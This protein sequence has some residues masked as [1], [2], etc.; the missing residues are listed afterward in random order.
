MKRFPA[1]LLLASFPLLSAGQWEDCRSGPFEIWTNGSDRD[2]RQ[3]L[4]RLEQ[5]DR[6]RGIFVLRAGF[7]AHRLRHHAGL[8]REMRGIR[9]VE[10]V[11]V[12][13][14]VSQHER[15]ILLAV[16]IDHAVE[17]LF[18]EL[19]R[20]VAAV[21]ELDLGAED[22]RLDAVERCALFLPRELAFAALAER[23]ADDLDAIALPDVQ[24][25]GAAGAPDEIAG[26][27]GDDESGFCFVGHDAS[28]EMQDRRV[29]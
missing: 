7:V 15:G 4:V 26:M 8:L 9:M 27:R 18:V 14:R 2:A 22:R 25:D 19:E 11:G 5:V 6:R 3:L 10:I 24:R 29:F 21:E 1:I 16:D 13:Q 28:L 17:M 20:I 23:Q 12:F